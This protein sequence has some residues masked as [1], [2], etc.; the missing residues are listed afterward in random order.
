M[1]VLIVD[2]SEDV[3]PEASLAD[4]TLNMVRLGDRWLLACY[5]LISRCKVILCMLLLDGL[6]EVPLSQIYNWLL[7]FVECD[8][9]NLPR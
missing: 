1:V 9:T 4:W 8:L 5:K 2:F 7:V 6:C 3:L